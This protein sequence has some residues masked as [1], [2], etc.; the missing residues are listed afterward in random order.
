MEAF[1]LHVSGADDIAPSVLRVKA[2]AATSTWNLLMRL[3]GSRG[4]YNQST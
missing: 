4:P 2:V 1:K 3:R